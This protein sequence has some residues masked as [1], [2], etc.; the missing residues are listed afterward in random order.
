MVSDSANPTQEIATFGDRSGADLERI[1]S[2][3]RLSRGRRRSRRRV[4]ITAVDAETASSAISH[5]ATPPLLAG[6]CWPA[7]T[8][9]FAATCST[10]AF[11]AF[12]STGATSV[13]T[14]T[15][16]PSAAKPQ[17]SSSL[18]CGQKF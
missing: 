8:T 4:T 9:G 14:G 11:G 5:D 12:G 6:S 15:T 18:A 17:S 13:P 10:A 3:G 7:A 2:G 1:Y 16:L